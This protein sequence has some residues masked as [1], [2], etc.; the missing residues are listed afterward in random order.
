MKY[1]KKPV[2]IE[3]IQWTGENIHEIWEAFTAEKIYGP[4]W[5]PE[6]GNSLVIE[7]LEGQMMC[8]LNHWVIKGVAGEIYACAPNIFEATYER[9]DEANIS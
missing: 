1:R 5:K 3:A 2:I 9:S 4:G 7:T 8:P 6:F